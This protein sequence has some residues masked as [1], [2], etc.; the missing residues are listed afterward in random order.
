MFWRKKK[1]MIDVRE[2]QKKGVIKI[3]TKNIE[4][5]T[6]KDGFVEIKKTAQQEAQQS[7]NQPSESGNFF[8]FIDNQAVSNQTQPISREDLRKISDQIS[9]LDNKLYKIEQRVELLE[10][11]VGI[12]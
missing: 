7:T 12:L 5:P 4:I 3:P 10:R 8:D 11:K 6:D 1:K 9:D 2:L